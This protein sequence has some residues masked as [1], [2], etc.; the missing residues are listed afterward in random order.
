[1]NVLGAHHLLFIVALLLLPI[2]VFSDLLFG[3]ARDE[4]N[5]SVSA[6]YQIS[7]S[8][9]SNI[10]VGTRI[11]RITV[12]GQPVIVS[13][14]AFDR[15]QG[16]ILYGVT[17]ANSPTFANSLVT[18]HPRTAVATRLGS[19]G[20]PHLA[21]MAAS[22]S[23][24]IYSWWIGVDDDN[25]ADDLVKFNLVPGIGAGT[26]TAFVVGNTAITTPSP[27]PP[28]SFGLDFDASDDT[29]IHFL[30]GDGTY[31]KIN[32]GDG[33]AQFVGS[34]RNNQFAKASV[35]SGS[36]A[37]NPD[38]LPSRI[39]WNVERTLDRVNLNT[40]IQT[41]DIDT[42]E[43]TALYETNVNGLDAIAFG[44]PMTQVRARM[45]G[46]FSCFFIVDLFFV[47][48]PVSHQNMVVRQAPSSSP[49][50]STMPSSS[51]SVSQMPSV[52][53]APTIFDPCN[54]NQCSLPLGFS[55]RQL[56]IELFGICFSTCF[57]PLFAGVFQLFGWVCGG[58]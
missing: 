32:V 2:G 4:S 25:R 31:Y 34:I 17:A 19:V 39:F 49:S 20:L 50:A 51:P 10:L 45:C 16:Q 35:R 38:T 14:L 37:L 22:S 26:G 24:D 28:H 43:S 18:I 12:N 30:N 9:S 40:L 46:R 42:L 54:V 21:A 47:R 1:M 57:L 7:T 36:W 52:S 29:T 13:G 3:A 53:S 5:G 6:L 27:T 58:C 56:Y 8:D 55:G 33:S 11:G 41:I 48:V 23:G 15:R 44:D